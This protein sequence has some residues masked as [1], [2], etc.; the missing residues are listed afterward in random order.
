[1]KQPQ[2][3]KDKKRGSRKREWEELKG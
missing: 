1:M 3:K 2:K